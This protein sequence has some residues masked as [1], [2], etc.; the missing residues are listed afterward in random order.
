[1]AKSSGDANT[2]GNSR[3][4][5]SYLV[6]Y[7]SG[8]LVG[9][10][11]VSAFIAQ[12]VF[13]TGGSGEFGEIIS[14]LRSKDAPLTAVLVVSGLLGL[15]YSYLVSAPIT[16]IH[17]GRGVRIF[18]D[19]QSRYFWLA[20][21]AVICLTILG[22]RHKAYSGV[23]SIPLVILI[24]TML[25]FFKEKDGEKPTF[26]RII[27]STAAWIFILLLLLSFAIGSLPTLSIWQ[28]YLL[29]FSL[30]AVWIGI[31]QYIS[32]FKILLIEEK[33]LE[34]YQ[35]LTRARKDTGAR[36]I[37]ET[38]SHLREH[39]NSTFIVIVELCFSCLL[40]L[41]ISLAVRHKQDFENFISGEAVN[42]MGWLLSIFMVWSIPN[43]FMWSR[44]NRMEKDFSDNPEKYLGEKKE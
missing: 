42:L 36:D 11:C 37:R 39:S 17:Y 38:Y 40:A 19:E 18:W 3:W 1:M 27:L 20:W 33:I 7:L 32:L 16:V 41:V 8:F 2:S 12:V 44:A 9:T 35:N 13:I 15:L 23:I 28:E 34:F 5:E 14:G 43:L 31:S 25:Y 6:R 26:A 29:V 4:W 24:I 22:F 10:I 30:P 21:V